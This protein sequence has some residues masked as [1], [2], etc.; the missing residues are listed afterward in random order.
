MTASDTGLTNF[1]KE[2]GIVT[3]QRRLCS[4]RVT[5]Q[6]PDKGK[7]KLLLIG[8]GCSRCADSGRVSVVKLTTKD[9][10]LIVTVNEPDAEVQVLT[11]EGTVEITK[12][13]KKGTISIS[14]DP[15]KHRL[16]VT[17]DGFSV[18]GQDFEIEAGGKQPITASLVP[19]E[20]EPAVVGSRV[21][22][23]EKPWDSPRLPGNR[24]ERRRHA[25]REA[26]GGS[27]QEAV[28]LNP[29]FDGKV[30]PMIEN[31]VVTELQFVTDNVTDISPVR[32]RT[33]GLEVSGKAVQWN[34]C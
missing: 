25:R 27:R 5:Q 21:V 16:K 32:A 34:T 26:G 33:H 29:G 22:G 9:G 8:G 14:V 4:S 23:G 20:D 28:E 1:L 30:T 6:L 3:G 11:E 24:E 19:L 10:T 15:G 17:K 2:V 12:K 31:G 13:G 7:K 18:F